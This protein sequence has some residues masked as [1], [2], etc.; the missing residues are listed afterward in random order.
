[1]MILVG[2]DGRG[3][4][5]CTVMLG[6]WSSRAVFLFVGGCGSVFVAKVKFMLVMCFGLWQFM[7]Y[8]GRI[9]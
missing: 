8:Y 6:L 7:E 5:E 3:G 4:F 2:Y 1:M 9:D